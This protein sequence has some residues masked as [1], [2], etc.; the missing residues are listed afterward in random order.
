MAETL[1]RC[2]HPAACRETRRVHD[3]KKPDDICADEAC[4]E[5]HSDLF[6]CSVCAEVAERDATHDR[7]IEERDATILALHEELSE[8]IFDPSDGSAP[9]MRCTPDL[10][11]RWNAE[12]EARV[13]AEDERDR[14]KN[15][16]HT[17]D[18]DRETAREENER[19]RAK[20]T[21]LVCA[22]RSHP[23]GDEDWAERVSDCTEDL[24][25]ALAP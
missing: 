21:D 13:K 12:R 16:A 1:G 22:L 23:P 6:R 3:P 2:G 4:Y 9:L 5:W 24:C 7:I 17:S 19:L 15:A 18:V 25:A 10:P 20:A 8:V 14:W 11:A